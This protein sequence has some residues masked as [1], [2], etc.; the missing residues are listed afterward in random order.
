MGFQWGGFSAG[1]NQGLQTADKLG[2]MWDQ[3]QAGRVRSMAIKEAKQTYA[4]NEAPAVAAQG[5]KPPGL[6]Q[7]EVNA[8]M[9]ADGGATYQVDT[10]GQA[11]LPAAAAPKKKNLGTEKQFTAQ[12]VADKLEQ[13]YLTAG[14]VG[15]A[16]KWNKWR[17]DKVNE[18]K[19]EDWAE[20]YGHSQRGD[21][22]SAAKKLINLHK[23]YDDGNEVVSANPFKD[24]TG[25]EAGFEMVYKDASG[26]E[27]AVKVGARELVE[28]G[29]PAMNPQAMYEMESRK[30]N[31]ADQARVKAAADAASDARDLKKQLTVATVREQGDDRRNAANN[32]VKLAEARITREGRMDELVMDNQLKNAGHGEKVRAEMRGKIDFLRSTGLPDTAINEMVPAL[33]GIDQAKGEKDPTKLRANAVKILSDTN[34]KFPKASEADQAVL[35][36][37]LVRVMT[38]AQQAAPAPAAAPR[39]PIKP[40]SAGPRAGIYMPGQGIVNR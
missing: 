1:L 9:P 23:D 35:V 27:T 32:A 37:S 3:A 29:M 17:K 40:A 31:Q 26:K 21:Y 28:M 19:M 6:A 39:A 24:E 25:R 30:I 33:L 4:Q 22:M 16:E 14:N 5:I 10:P 7:S 13:H 20:A 15:E 34:H 18:R 12:L 36:D 38:G 8:P 11:P 2:D